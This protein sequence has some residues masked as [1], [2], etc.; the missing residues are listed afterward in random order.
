MG[1]IFTTRTVNEHFLDFAYCYIKENDLDPENVW[2]RSADKHNRFVRIEKY[3]KTR[4]Y[5]F[6]KLEALVDSDNNTL[7]A[8]GDLFSKTIAIY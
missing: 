3:K 1:R 8:A 4:A 7:V 5:Y 6:A 2:I